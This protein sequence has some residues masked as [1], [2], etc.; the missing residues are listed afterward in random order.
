[1]PSVSTTPGIIGLLAALALTA[2]T[3]EP[4]PAC[5]DA[6]SG[7]LI[8]DV[9]ILDGTGAAPVGGSVRVQDGRIAEVGDVAACSGERVVDGGGQVLAPG[10][11]DT[12]SHA[13]ED[14]LDKPDALP[15]VSQGITT[16]VVGQDGESKY[17]LADFFAKLEAAPPTVNVAS[18][19]GHGTLRSKVMGDDFKRPASIDE[20]AYMKA[21]LADE[22]DSGA[23]GL[24]TGLE[25]EPGIYSKTDE[26]IELAQVAADAGG[27]YI[28]H[29][30]SEDR[31]FEAAID[32]IIR[33]GRETHMPV[34]V[35]HI[36]LAMKRLWGTAP[37]LIA[38][39]DAARAEGIDITADIYP[40]TYWQ[41]TIMVLLPDRDPTDREAIAEVLDQIAPADGIWFT[42]F[43]PDPTYVGKTLSE[44]AA[45]RKED[46]VTAFSE[47]AQ[48]ALAWEKEHGEGAE[49]IIGTSMTDADVEKLF[50]WPYADVCTDG[51]IVDLHPRHIGSFPRVLGRFVREDHVVPLAEAVRKMTGLAAHNMGFTDRGLIRSGYAADLVLF[52]P[53]TVI[54]RATPQQPDLLSAGITTVWVGGEVVYRDG[55]VTDAR[56]GKVI[57]RKMSP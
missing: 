40:Y 16:V 35:S 54:D 25:Y 37:Q 32:E 1:V 52:D 15:D 22:L 26:V 55:A 3:E 42:Q 21:L 36:K 20:I 49:Q 9:R 28:S 23:L 38:K 8:T 5:S 56:P 53:D 24:S 57:R 2:C 33:I 34:Q 50:A 18:Y 51:A 27:R 7:F 46:A 44:I 39:L 13:D 45:L 11:I 14:I 12:H 41:S 17:P 29:V 47:I 43:E 6:A 4:V 19:V 30:R 48:E 10:F 31:W